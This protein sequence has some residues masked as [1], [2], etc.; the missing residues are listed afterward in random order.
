MRRLLIA[1]LVLAALAL[2]A[3]F[4]TRALAQGWV[5]SQIQTSLELSERPDVSFDTFP[6]LPRFLSGELPTV[7]V[8]AATITAEGIE[9]ER[10]HLELHDVR[11]SPSALVRGRSTTITA[12]EGSGTIVVTG[13]ALT[14]A[15]RRHDIPVTVRFR[16]SRAEISAG[17]LTPSVPLKPTI[18]GAALVLSATVGSF[19]LGLPE[20]VPGVVYRGV[21]VEGSAVVL[22]FD[23]ED[24]SFET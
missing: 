21:R 9:F 19:R 18:A 17:G 22:S 12:P 24:A 5:A 3:D 2:A 15:L 23:I 20:V 13:E 16:G 7:T 14:D 10:A 8:D 1:V 6:F 11:F 4:G